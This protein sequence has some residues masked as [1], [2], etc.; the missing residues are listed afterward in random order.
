MTAATRGASTGRRGASHRQAPAPVRRA[1]AG[2]AGRGRD[3]VAAV[4][5]GDRPLALAVVGVVAVSAL[6][7]ARPLTTYLDG[8]E[9]VVLLDAKGE[10]LREE[11]AR[12]EARERD[13]TTAE[14]VELRARERLG[15]VRPGEI[16]YVVITPETDR[17]R[18]ASPAPPPPRPWY[19]RLLD[20]LV[21]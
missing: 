18:L 13:L 3:A 7:L 8:R 20:A 12:L 6:M 10:A 1:V 16:P 11:I 19:R 21:P 14:H 15:L 4:L 17:P 2:A 9:R 5:A